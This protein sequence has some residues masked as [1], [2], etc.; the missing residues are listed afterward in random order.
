[1]TRTGGRHAGRERNSPRAGIRFALARVLLLTAADKEH[2]MKASE[3]PP[4]VDL[5]LRYFLRNPRAADDLEGIVRW[6]LRRL[7]IE[8]SVE[9]AAAA[10]NWLAARGFLTVTR[11]SG[12]EPLF[13]INQERLE[14][15]RRFVETLRPVRRRAEPPQTCAHCGHT[16]EPIEAPWQRS[17]RPVH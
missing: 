17:L 10:V 15:A 7:Q 1:V 8:E 6:R 4:K 9:E 14:E 3:I 12:G 2:S 13:A 5:V 16:A 11:R